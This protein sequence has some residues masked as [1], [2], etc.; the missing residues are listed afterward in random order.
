MEKQKLKELLDIIEKDLSAM[1]SKEFKAAMR[2]VKGTEFYKILERAGLGF[3]KVKPKVNEPF[4]EKCIR[5]GIVLRG[6]QGVNG[7]KYDITSERKVK[8]KE[9]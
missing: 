4:E 3:L 1:N 5:E 9:A 2:E 7:S 6:A 8:R